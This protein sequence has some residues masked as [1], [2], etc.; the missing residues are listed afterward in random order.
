M[1]PRLRGSVRHN[2]GGAE[3]DRSGDNE[4]AAKIFHR[5]ATKLIALAYK[6]LGARVRQKLD[7]DDVVQSVF[8][9]FFGHQRAGDLAGLASW[10]NVW[11]L[12]VAMTVRKCHSRRRQFHAHRRDVR[13]EVPLTSLGWEICD[14]EPT[15]EEAAMLADT[16]NELVNHFEGR[17]QK[18]LLLLLEDYSALEISLK[19]G[20]TE[21]TVHRN[22][23]YIREWLAR[24]ADE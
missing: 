4:A 8:R 22:F 18:I 11:G 21:R 19:L 13:K 16:V 20:C 23:G 14:R 12:L 9:S 3:K 15:P 24:R 2:F 1:A 10:D 6:K 7:A 17:T 5:F